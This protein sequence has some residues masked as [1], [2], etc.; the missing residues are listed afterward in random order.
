MS[1]LTHFEKRKIQMEYVVP[2]VKDLQEILGEGV[3]LQALEELGRRRYERASPRAQI[4]VSQIE[5]MLEIYAAGGSLDYDLI[6]SSDDAFDINI[7]GCRYAEM[8]EELGG[9][10]FGHLLICNGDFVGAREMGLELERTQTRMQGAD[11]CDF[12]YK[13]LVQED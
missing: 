12:R 8:M 11:H 3:V 4:D 10:E 9:R 13:P 1:E 5:P 2:L 6:A 7:T